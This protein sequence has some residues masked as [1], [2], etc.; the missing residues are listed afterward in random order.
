MDEPWKHYAEWMKPNTADYLIAWFHLHEMSK[1]GKF[2]E[3]E[4]RSVF[5][6]NCGWEQEL[7][8]GGQDSISGVM[9]MF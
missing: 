9:D 7:T 3:I 6:L 2:I 5:A 4:N 1:K 8:P